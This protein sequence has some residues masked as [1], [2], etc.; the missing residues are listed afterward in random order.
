MPA[1]PRDTNAC[2]GLDMSRSTDALQ[3]TAFGALQ[4]VADHAA[5][6]RRCPWAAVP[7]KQ[8]RWWC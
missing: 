7:W 5:Y 4:P 8:R 6:G 3:M 1:I 2:F